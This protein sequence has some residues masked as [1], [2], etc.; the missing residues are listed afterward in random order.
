MISA[1]GGAG[2]IG[3]T[4][5]ALH[6]AHRHARPVPRRAAVRGPA[7]LQPG[8][9]ADGTGGGGCAGSST[10]WASTPAAIPVDPDAQAALYRSLVAGQADADRAGQRRRPP[11]RSMPAAARRPTC[12]VLVT[13]RSTLAG[14]ITRHG[15][16]HLHLDVLTDAEAR[17]LLTARLGADRVAA[18]PD[19]VDGADRAVRRLSRW[20]WAS[21]PPAPPPTRTVPLAEFAAELRDLGL[22]ALDDDDPTASLPAVLSWSY[23]AL[24]DRAARRCSRCWASPPAP[25]SACPPPPASPACPRHRPRR[26]LRGLEDAS[27]L[28]RDA[29]GRYSMHDLVRAYAT[30][31]RP[32]PAPRR[33]AGGSAAAGRRLLPAHRPHRRPT[34]GPPPPADPARPARPRLPPPPAARRSRRRWPGSTPSTP[35]CWPPSTPPPPTTGTRPCGTWP[36]P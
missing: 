16:H 27:L 9:R 14:L 4:W 23:R 26:V 6:W 32:R 30:D 12:T 36:G 10:P 28:D 13:S 11:T 21:S 7:R 1:I 5:L 33:R 2:G 17:A 15:A 29:H 19:A 18:E 31:H 3:K 8:Q 34:P 35:A 22:D 20:R 24:T 25:T